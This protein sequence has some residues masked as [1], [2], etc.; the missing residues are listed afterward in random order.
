MK[1]YTLPLD[2]HFQRPVVKLSNGLTALLD[3][4]AFILVWTDKEELLKR[5][6]GGRFIKS[7]MP[8]NGF[9]GKTSGNL[10]R[11]TLNIGEIIYPDLIHSL[12]LY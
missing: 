10:Y 1:Q 6:L 7:N 8:L 4:G 11:V 12:I 5:K 3:T 2:R 9:G